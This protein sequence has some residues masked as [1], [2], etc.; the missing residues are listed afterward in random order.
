MSRFRR[1]SADDGQSRVKPVPETG[2]A[3][4]AARE[5]SQ[6][7][8]GPA[9]REFSEYR[10]LSSGGILC[11]NRHNPRWGPARLFALVSG[12]TMLDGACLHLF[13][14][15]GYPDPRPVS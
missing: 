4:D 14:M 8:L 15:I 9:S 3:L 7:N 10:S 5:R 2:R 11:E 13:G 1:A 12:G 6:P